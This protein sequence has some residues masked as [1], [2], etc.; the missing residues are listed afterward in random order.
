MLSPRIKLVRKLLKARLKN[1]LSQRQVAARAGF[2]QPYLAQVESGIR[3]I[4]KNAA[5]QL[6]RIYG[7][8]AGT[9][10]KGAGQRGRPAFSA[11]TA[12]AMR[13][14]PRAIQQFWQKAKVRIPTHQQPHQVKRADDPLWPMAIH[15]GPEAAEEVV[16]LEK[17]RGQDP[18]FWHQ[19]NSLRLD[20]WSE[21]RLLVGVAL[22]GGQ[23]LGVRLRDLGCDLPLVDGV[24]GQ[25]PG[26]HR[27]FVLK[28]QAAS[29]LWCP[30]VAIRTRTGHRC[31]DN[32]LVI[33]G[34]GK[35]V[36]LGVEVNGAPF[37]D[38]PW[39]Q[40]QRDAELG[41]PILHLDAARIGEPGL[42]AKILQWAHRQLREV[43]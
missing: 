4:S 8:R 22:L 35:T 10:T 31:V 34:G 6:E 18:A 17:L 2:S 1:R 19:F 33:S 9:Y 32:L 29:V 42:I 36:S 11:E 21:K 7:A 15:L 12:A 38:D 27:A 16:R 25:E 24:T 5:H 14:F 20:S 43:A 30:Q 13:E 28:G 23:M 37:H 3:P 40:Q 41:F 26:L 39:K